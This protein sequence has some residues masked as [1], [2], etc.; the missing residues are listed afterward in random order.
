MN[1]ESSVRNL[2]Y[3]HVSP[4]STPPPMCSDASA[5]VIA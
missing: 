3:Q 1:E 4:H 5:N 2:K